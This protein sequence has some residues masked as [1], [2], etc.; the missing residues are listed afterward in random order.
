MSLTIL[1]LIVLGAV[2][3][4][5]LLAAVRGFTREVLSIASW[6]A[7]AVAAWSFH[8]LLLPF[9]KQH[10]KQDTI[11]LVV[12]IAAIFLV[13]LVIVSLI[14]ARIS[15]FVLDS[16]I[17]A[18][19]RTLGLAFGAARGLLLAVVGYLLW[20]TLVPETR[21]PDWVRD[22][23]TKP[24]LDSSGKTLL[25]MLPQDIDTSFIKN[26]AP[27]T[28]APT[29]APAEEPRPPAQVQPQRRT[30]APGGQVDRASLQRAVD[31]AQRQPGQPQRP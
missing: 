17:G 23:K 26:L 12:A 4:S 21:Q 10:V 27:K 13:T 2:A 5:A 8:P 29:E 11:A 6:V 14:T 30:E 16:R 3:L 1:D 22:A 28:T 9:V 15:D 7:A 18:L 24:L 20:T 25:A 31:N 19:D